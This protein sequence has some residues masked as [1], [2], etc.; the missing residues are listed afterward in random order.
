MEMISVPGGGV[1]ERDNLSFYWSELL[2]TGGDG[3]IIDCDQV[4]R[5]GILDE[6]RVRDGIGQ[7]GG[8]RCGLD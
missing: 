3:V 4:S 2:G 6:G 7:E 8:E 5:G 1:S